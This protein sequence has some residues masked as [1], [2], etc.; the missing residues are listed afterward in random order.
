M[1]RVSLWRMIC[2]ACGTKAAVVRI[3][4]RL[5]TRISIVMSADRRGRVSEPGPVVAEQNRL[6]LAPHPRVI[7]VEPGK[8]GGRELFRV[9]QPPVER[10][11][12]QGL[13]AHHL[14]V[15]A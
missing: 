12:R 13:E 6:D 7:G 15:A 9:D 4:A 1:A 11:Q 14:P 2:S 8:L 10:H 5:E 3:A